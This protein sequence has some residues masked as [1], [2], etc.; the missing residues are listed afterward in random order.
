MKIQKQLH[1]T[2]T[3]SSNDSMLC[4]FMAQHDYKASSGDFRW[5]C[6]A[7]SVGWKRDFRVRQMGTIL[8]F[9]YRTTNGYR[10]FKKEGLWVSGF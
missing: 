10:N 2:S 5:V 3:V 1:S 8:G 4:D 9:G 7:I 6:T